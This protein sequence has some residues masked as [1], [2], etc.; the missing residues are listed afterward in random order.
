[1]P[2]GDPHAQAVRHLL[3]QRLACQWLSCGLNLDVGYPDAFAPH[4]SLA[5]DGHIN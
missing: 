4:A 5:S 1:M 2:R 3:W